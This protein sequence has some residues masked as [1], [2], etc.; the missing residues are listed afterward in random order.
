VSVTND[1]DRAATVALSGL[2]GLGH[3]RLRRII[4]LGRPADTWVELVRIGPRRA[5][6]E[7]DSTVDLRWTEH[8]RRIDPCALLDAHREAGVGVVLPGDPTF[9]AS[10][11]DDH[12]PSS[13]LFHLGDP[14]VVGDDAASIVGTRRSTGY[15]E[16][17]AFDL[18]AELSRAGVSVVSGLAL[19]IDGAA[20]AGAL[21]VPASPPVA[22]V[23]CGL[24]VVYPRR[25][26]QLWRAVAAHGVVWS[27]A[28]LGV[29]PERWRFPL[30]NR[31]IAA[32]GSVLV[33][34]E[35]G[36]AGG[37]MHTVREAD[38]RGRTVMAVPGP[39]RNPASLGPNQLLSEGCPPC[40]DHEDVLVALG[41]ATESVGAS[42]TP[43]ISLSL[44]ASAVL[45]A[46]EWTRSTIDDL[47]RRSGCDVAMVSVAVSE[48]L[49]AGQ[50][51]PHGGLFERCGR[52]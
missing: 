34:V 22:V 19:G 31:L 4:E 15:G 2:P 13:V 40:R 1:D 7:V 5:G 3:R 52:S 8:A 9:P 47:V 27:E 11:A 41:L 51:R 6:V 24:D 36:R 37:S 35:S 17:V 12:D 39:V 50:I 18:G 30:R 33:V 26:G 48:L 38:D 29:P 32:L 28:P 23:A 21:S 10:L 44:T 42:A 46:F 14:T 43:S 20:H 16:S 49:E 45:D 25:N